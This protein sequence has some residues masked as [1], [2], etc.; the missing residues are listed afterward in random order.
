MRIAERLS[1]L[2]TYVFATIGRRVRALQAEGVDVIRLHIGNPDLPPPEPVVEMLDCS[3][4]DLH[5][6]GYSSFSGTPALR[7]AI[8]DYYGRRFGV[9]LDPESEVLPLIGSKG[10]VFHLLMAFVDPGTV[11][12]APDPGYPTYRNVVHLVGGELYRI[13]LTEENAWLPDLGAIPAETL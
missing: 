11:V 13:P 5:K 8:A 10:G 4:R 9:R 1:N 12:L 7:K 2:P 6:H 3:A